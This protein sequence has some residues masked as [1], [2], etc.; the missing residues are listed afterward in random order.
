M[1]QV[2]ATCHD[3]PAMARLLGR[4]A[5][6]LSYRLGTADGVRRRT[7]VGIWSITHHADV[8]F[9]DSFL[10]SLVFTFMQINR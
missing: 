4:R 8:S 3:E 2:S 7:A 9:R 10:Q 5:A 6:I 1:L